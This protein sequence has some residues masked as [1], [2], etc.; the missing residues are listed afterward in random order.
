MFGHFVMVGSG[1]TT[2]ELFEDVA[3]HPSPVSRY[4][5]QQLLNKLKLRTMLTG[6]RQFKPVDLEQVIQKILDLDNLIQ[7]NPQIEELDINPLMILS[8]GRMYV[9]DARIKKS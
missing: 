3:F 4:S 9:I 5:V 1:G 7:N 8:D 6:F 2:I